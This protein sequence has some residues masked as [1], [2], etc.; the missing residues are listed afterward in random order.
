MSK[1]HWL[2]LCMHDSMDECTEVVFR[3]RSSCSRHSSS[4]SVA[5]RNKI[6]M[7]L[8]SWWCLFA[9][10]SCMSGRWGVRRPSRGACRRHKL[11]WSAWLQNLPHKS[12]RPSRYDRQT[13]GGSVDPVLRCKGRLAQR[14]DL[15]PTSR[16]AASCKIWRMSQVSLSILFSCRGTNTQISRLAG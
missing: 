4:G 3:H 12:V 6:V 15:V 8:L 9:Y 2:L 7:Q 13:K 14:V 16:R 11:R 1:K 10:R 5:C